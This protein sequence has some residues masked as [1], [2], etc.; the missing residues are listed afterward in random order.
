MRFDLTVNHFTKSFIEKETLE[1]Y[2]P[3]TWRP[4]CHVKDFARLIH[5]VIICEKKLI[6]YQIFNAGN[7]KNNFTKKVF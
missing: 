4:Y 7:N 3:N 5:K 1:V 2:D 6:N